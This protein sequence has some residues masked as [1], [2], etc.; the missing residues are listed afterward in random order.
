LSVARL[1]AGA[2]R[3]KRRGYG[4]AG[5]APA[6]GLTA[7]QRLLLLDTWLRSALPAG[8][9]A[10]MLGGAVSKHT[11]YAWKKRFEEQGPAGL[12]DQPR[13]AR[14]GS[15][16]PEVTRRAILM[17]KRGNPEWGC[18]RLSDMLVRSPGVPASPRAVARVLSEAGYELREEPTKPHP[19]KVRS[20][21]RAKPNQLWQTDL[22]TFMLKRQ[23]RRVYLVA[24]MDDHSRFAAGRMREGSA[25]GLRR[26][27]GRG[28]EAVSAERT[29]P[30]RQS[31]PRVK[32][33]SPE[34]RKTAAAILEVLAGNLTPAD[35][36]AAVGVSPPRY[37][38]LESRALSGLVGACEPRAK[39]PGHSLEK[40]L[41]ALRRE[42]ERT[43]RELARAQALARASQR[44][45]GLVVPQKPARPEGKMKK[46]RPVVRALRAAANLKAEPPKPLSGAGA[47][48][49]VLDNRPM[50]EKG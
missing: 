25:R 48:T 38:L 9:F 31:G 40:E 19:D 8:D 42:H 36:A 20:F 45:V 18:Q 14:C 1:V 44:A 35:A 2:G 26:A 10:A 24:F 39:G 37:Y 22:F 33:G 11:L 47:G 6:S 5:A 28:A 15:R 27:R 21:E 41:E 16:L 23:N 50:I 12:A 29:R 32:S 4:E 49:P 43:R 46:R 3:K 13:G 17:L 30:P 34:A 7:E